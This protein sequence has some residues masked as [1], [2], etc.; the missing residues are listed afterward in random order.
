MF[1]GHSEKQFYRASDPT[2]CMSSRSWCEHNMHR[3]VP[4]SWKADILHGGGGG[5]SSKS[6]YSGGDVCR[7][8]GGS[9][10]GIVYLQ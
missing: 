7:D 6:I 4:H 5:S 2:Q 10:V 3:Y 1:F 8:G 9:G